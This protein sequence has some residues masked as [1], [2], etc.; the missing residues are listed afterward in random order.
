MGSSGTR[1]RFSAERYGSLIALAILVVVSAV[2]EEIGPA[3]RAHGQRR[4]DALA[5]L[6]ALARKEA[7]ARPALA[8]ARSGAGVRLCPAP[9]GVGAGSRPT[10]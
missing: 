5:T 2:L 4:Q 7:L 8:Q 3:V 10:P 6:E 1:S 9:P